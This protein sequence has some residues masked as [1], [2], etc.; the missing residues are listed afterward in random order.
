MKNIKKST[1]ADGT[2]IQI[3]D[4]EDLLQRIQKQKIQANMVL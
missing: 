4:W 3:E 2:N 1:M